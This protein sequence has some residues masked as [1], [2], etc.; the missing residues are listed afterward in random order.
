M[1]LALC[2]YVEVITMHRLRVVFWTSIMMFLLII[3]CTPKKIVLTGKVLDRV[4]GKPIPNAVVHERSHEKNKTRTGKNG[5]YLLN[6]II[7]EEHFIY[8]SARGFHPTRKTFPYNAR[9]EKN[10]YLMNFVLDRV[11]SASGRKTP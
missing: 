1:N 4:S 3:N 7:N 2:E 6:G 8:V 10:R 5:F 11:S 9:K